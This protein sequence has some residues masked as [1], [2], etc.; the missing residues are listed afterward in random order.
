M[1]KYLPSFKE[2]NPQHKKW[3]VVSNLSKSFIFSLTTYHT[4]SL[5][6]D[7]LFYDTWNAVEFK[8]LGCLYAAIDM[9]SILIVPKLAKNTYYHHVVVNILYFYSLLNGMA[10][11]S[12]SRLVVVY[13]LFSV[14]AFLVN[15]FLGLRIIIKDQLFLKYFSSI[16]L[17][18]YILCCIPNW[19]FLFYNLY[20]NPVYGE[21]YGLIGNSLFVSIILVV[22]YDDLVLM[23]YLKDNSLFPNILETSLI[24]NN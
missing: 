14:L 5:I 4:Y 12:Y 22:M 2:I 24:K 20:F 15:T 1:D 11:D 19:S 23:K 7:N 17:V 18:N 6:I 13:A 8:Y 21:Q 9:S 16:C 3:Y 10:K